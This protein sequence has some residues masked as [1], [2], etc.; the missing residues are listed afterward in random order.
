[1]PRRWRNWCERAGIGRPQVKGGTAHA[2]RHLV[3]APA[4]LVGISTDLSNQ[5][6]SAFKTFGLRA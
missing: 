1:M 4:Q 6:R 3:N 5:I 2:V